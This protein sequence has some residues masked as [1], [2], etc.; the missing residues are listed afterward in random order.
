MKKIIIDK[1]QA[2]SRT[3]LVENGKLIEVLMDDS[4]LASKVGNVY[5]AKI[6]NIFKTFAFAEIGAKKK[7]FLQLEDDIKVKSG[8]RVVVQI[9]KDAFKDKGAKV[10][11]NI[12]FAGRYIVLTKKNTSSNTIYI[13]RKIEDE[14]EKARLNKIAADILPTNHSIIFRSASKGIEKKVI[15]NELK[16]LAAKIESIVNHNNENGVL[17]EENNIAIYESSL[18]SLFCENIDA[19]AI[20]DENEIKNLN[21]IL[22]QNGYG[23]TKVDLHAD[24]NIFEY[25]ELD[26]QIEKLKDKK[27]WLKTGGYVVIEKTEALTVIDVNTGKLTSKK[28][29]TIKKANM[30][31]ATEIAKQLR[32]RNLFGIIIVDF[33]SMEE[34]S[35][36]DELINHFSNEVKKDRLTVNVVGITSLGLVELTRKGT[37]ANN[38]F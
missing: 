29:D 37:K 20:N 3:A 19:I 1:K 25:Y 18:K 30:E 6:E 24:E 38:I 5:L 15:E 14:A 7:A 11:T 34:A 4:A 9:T 16:S 8:D 17:Y 27:V 36:K 12:T 26:H 35:S 23:G 10:S 31:A 13:S 21:L 2:T 32:L 22:K 28:K 33:I